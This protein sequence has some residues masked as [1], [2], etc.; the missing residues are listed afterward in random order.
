MVLSVSLIQFALRIP[1]K[2][3]HVKVFW[4]PSIYL[5]RNWYRVSCSDAVYLSLNIK[6]VF[7]SVP[8]WLPLLS[9]VNGCVRGSTR[10]WSQSITLVIWWCFFISLF[11]KHFF[12][13]TAPSE[14]HILSDLQPSYSSHVKFLFVCF[15]VLEE[16]SQYVQKFQSDKLLEVTMDV[17]DLFELF[18]NFR[19]LFCSS[20]FALQPN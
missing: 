1:V 13:T 18:W 12:H 3:C 11:L 9:G 14:K 8:A 15:I 6:W 7:S 5:R 2:C 19:Y 4:H 20:S 10:K 17:L 16:K